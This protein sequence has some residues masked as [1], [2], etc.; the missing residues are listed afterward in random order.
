MKRAIPLPHED[1]EQSAMLEPAIALRDAP[2][3]SQTMM[4]V[5]Q[6]DA[7]SGDGQIEAMRT[8]VLTMKEKGPMTQDAILRFL[9]EYQKEQKQ[10]EKER[11]REMEKEIIRGLQQRVSSAQHRF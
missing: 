1:G 8:L 11:A 6:I 2:G 4:E 3:C 7:L 9:G 10:T 5:A